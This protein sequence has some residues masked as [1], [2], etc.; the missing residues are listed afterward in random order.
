MST[1]EQDQNYILTE[2]IKKTDYYY[3]L[4]QAER[5]AIEEFLTL[6]W[7]MEG[8]EASYFEDDDDANA[9]GIT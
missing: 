2:H 5:Q 8:S 9:K 1:P 6:Q 7:F 4:S 3:R